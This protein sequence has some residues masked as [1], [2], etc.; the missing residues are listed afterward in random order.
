MS[1]LYILSLLYGQDDK[2][3]EDRLRSYLE[4]SFREIFEKENSQDE[5][6]PSFK[7]REEIEI[8]ILGINR[9]FNKLDT[10]T[11][12][13]QEH[14]YQLNQNLLYDFSSKT[15]L[16]GDK[17][18]KLNN[19]ERTLLEYLIKNRGT[20]VPYETLMYIISKNLNIHS[21]IETLRT[22][23]KR[24]RAKTDRLVIETISKI[25]YRI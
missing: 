3:I 20:T 7:Y 25:G 13:H 17:V 5:M 9:I 24:L 19:Q 1:N 2:K 12:E 10:H 6:G 15:I 23:V 14:I 16:N 11:E 22:V 4:N 8:M 18:V 21:S